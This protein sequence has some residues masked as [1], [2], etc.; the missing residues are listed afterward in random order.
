[1]CGVAKLSAK[2]EAELAASSCEFAGLE[3][4]EVTTTGCSRGNIEGTNEEAPDEWK[5]NGRKE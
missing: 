5:V 2:L 4:L 1:M 3:A